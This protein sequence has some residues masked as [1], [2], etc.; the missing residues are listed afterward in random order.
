MHFCLFKSSVPLILSILLERWGFV[1]LLFNLIGL[2]VLFLLLVGCS[3][4]EEVIYSGSTEHWNGKLVKYNEK[5][6]GEF[7]IE[8]IGDDM[9][10]LENVEIDINNGNIINKY[11][12]LSAEEKI[13]KPISKQMLLDFENME[14][15]ELVIKSGNEN[16]ER[17]VLTRK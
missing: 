6:Y 15:I 17:M 11:S 10:N 9:D 1:K 8:R 16:S 14:S 4:S 12:K 13:F 2:L 7:F 3:N 5:E